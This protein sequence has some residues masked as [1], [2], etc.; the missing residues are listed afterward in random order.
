MASAEAWWKGM[1]HNLLKISSKVTYSSSAAQDP[2]A[3]ARLL[4]PSLVPRDPASL[5]RLQ[6]T[7]AT[8]SAVSTSIKAEYISQQEGHNYQHTQTQT[9]MC[10][11]HWHGLSRRLTGH[12]LQ[13]PLWTEDRPHIGHACSQP[14]PFSSLAV[15]DS[16][17]WVEAHMHTYMHSLLTGTNACGCHKYYHAGVKWGTE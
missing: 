11:R 5:L 12:Y 8:F 14:H 1:G 4:E 10:Q 13:P 3:P 6:T 9:Q 17:S 7:A 16:N 2:P 15:R